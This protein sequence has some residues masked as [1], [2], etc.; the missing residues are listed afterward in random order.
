M[1]RGD[2]TGPAGMGPMTGRAAGFCAGFNS[3]GYMNPYGGRG[4]GARG[5]FGRGRGWRNQYFATGMPG[6]QRAGMGMPAW[7]AQGYGYVP[8]QGFAAPSPEQEMT[9][10]KNQ[11]EYLENS[12]KDIRSRMNELEKGEGK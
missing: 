12:L 7:G 11:A 5:G 4:M 8:Q 10:L 9:A 6:W 2:G 1:P 3:P